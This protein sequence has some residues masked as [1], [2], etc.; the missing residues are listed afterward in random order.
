MTFLNRLFLWLLVALTF[1]A[2]GLAAL[3]QTDRATLEG[4]VVDSSEAVIADANIKATATSTGIT[5]QRSS[6][7]AGYYRFPGMPVGDYTVEISRTAF[8]TK[9]FQ[10]II[11]QVGETDTLDVQLQIGTLR[12]KVVVNAA[13]AAV[14]RASAEAATVIRDD[15]IA[16]LPVNGRGWA[17][18]TLYA[19]FAQDDGGGDQRTIR[20]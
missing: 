9:V 3:A 16:N 20:F 17:E 15:Q 1:A 4:T 14:E 18:L 10:H 7:S 2:S 11:L 12:E 19:P 6:N 13:D 5:F 8:Q